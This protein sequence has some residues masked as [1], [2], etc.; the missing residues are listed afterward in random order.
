MKI[1]KLKPEDLVEIM[2]IDIT[3]TTSWKSQ[4][5]AESFAPVTCFSVGYFINIDDEVIRISDTKDT[6][7]ERTVNVIIKSCVKKIIKLKR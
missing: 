1:P 3:S 7:G 6:E 2:W 5:E 4:E